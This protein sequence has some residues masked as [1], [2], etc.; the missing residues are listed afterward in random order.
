MNMH[1]R[2]GCAA[3]LFAA[4]A[5]SSASAQS[6][7]A[8][9]VNNGNGGVQN[10]ATD[11][12]GAAESAGAPGSE[13]VNWNNLGRWGG[14]TNLNDE[15][16]AA[17]GVNFAWDANNVWNDGAGTAD[18]NA[19]LMHGYL[20]SNGAANVEPVTPYNFFPGVANDP[21]VFVNGLSAWLAA[22]GATSYSVV[23]YADGDGTD[24]RVGEYWLQEASGSDLGAL[25]VGGDLTPHLFNNDTANYTGTFDLVSSSS[26]ALEGADSGNYMVFTGLTADSFLLRTNEPAG[27]TLRTAINAVQIVA[28]PEPAS[29][30]VLGVAALS[31]LARRRRA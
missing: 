8:N 10:G 16:G 3:A 2:F 28:V 30:G 4:A 9:F 27:P 29:L 12:L 18:A 17:S 11:S 26:T 19:K 25:T 23:V 13:Q 24:G 7:G 21:H 6:I 14:L 22:R 31:L 1:V 20:D 15:T 5:T